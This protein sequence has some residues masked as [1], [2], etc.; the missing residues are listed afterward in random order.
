MIA[1]QQ[2]RPF[3]SRF[4]P[5][6]TTKNQIKTYKTYGKCGSQVNP[7]ARK[8]GKDP[9]AVSQIVREIQRKAEQHFGE[10][11]WDDDIAEI[12]MKPLKVWI[13]DIETAP[14]E[15]WVWRYW[16]ENIGH[17]MV[18]SYGHLMSY[19][20]KWLGEEEE[21]EYEELT[22]KE[23]KNK[24]DKRLVKNIIDRFSEADVVVAHNG[25]AF[26]SK[27]VTGRALVHNIKPPDRDWETMCCASSL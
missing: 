16:N 8:L 4:L 1:N 10:M 18:K 21:V 19:A 11:E 26:D 27:T 22:R 12:V 23:M 14:T 9:S 13:Y 17:N 6:A 5:F 2:C 3:D 20:G 15:A 25:R 7:T 24:N